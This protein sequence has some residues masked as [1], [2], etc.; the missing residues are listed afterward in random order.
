MVY[1]I[2]IHPYIRNAVMWL[3]QNL[4]FSFFVGMFF[5]VFAVDIFYSFNVVAKIRNAA[6]ENG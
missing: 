5:G 2:L 3:A 4:A 1:Y 6:I